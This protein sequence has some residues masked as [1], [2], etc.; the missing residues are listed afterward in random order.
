M[1]CDQI[2]EGHVFEVQY[3]VDPSKVWYAKVVSN[4]GGRLQLKHCS[5]GGCHGDGNED[6]QDNQVVPG[7]EGKKDTESGVMKE[8]GGKDV[9]N[10]WM[11]YTDHRL[12]AAGWVEKN[13]TDDLQF[14]IQPPQGLCC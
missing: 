5:D 8:A 9:E 13:S 10:F 11:F 7:H 4:V 3:D 2:K 6:A 12:H 14:T 1:P